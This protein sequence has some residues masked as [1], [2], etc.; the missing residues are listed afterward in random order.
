MIPVVIFT[1]SLAEADISRCYELG[2]NCYLVKPGNLADYVAVVRSM[3]D[4]WLGYATLPIRR[5]NE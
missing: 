4:F 3:A 1:T 5:R 2:A